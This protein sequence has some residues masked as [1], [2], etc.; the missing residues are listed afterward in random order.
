MHLSSV[1]NVFGKEIFLPIKIGTQNTVE[2]LCI[3]LIV[4]SRKC[5]LEYDHHIFDSN[6]GI[7]VS[8]NVIIVRSGNSFDDVR[9]GGSEFVFYH[10]GDYDEPFGL[11][12]PR[13]DVIQTAEVR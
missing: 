4:H 11:P 5:L 6:H 10:G 3:K 8:Y 1:Y 12:S 13:N 9:N 7:L 2:Y